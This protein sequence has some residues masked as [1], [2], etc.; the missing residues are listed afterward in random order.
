[1]D[2]PIWKLFGPLCSEVCQ[3]VGI[4]C[5]G[6]LVANFIVG[7]MLLIPMCSPHSGSWKVDV[8][9]R[10]WELDFY[11]DWGRRSEALGRAGIMGSRSL[12]GRR[13]TSYFLSI[14]CLSLH[15]RNSKLIASLGPS[16]LHLLGK[17]RV[18]TLFVPCVRTIYQS[19]E[20][21]TR[22]NCLFPLSWYLIIYPTWPSHLQG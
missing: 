19:V 22:T 13:H 11:V 6:L 4:G 20:H 1:M 17:S 5:N 9:G 2:R 10:V 7:S 14:C 3:I 18:N 16:G 12:A 15:I 21:P 8:F